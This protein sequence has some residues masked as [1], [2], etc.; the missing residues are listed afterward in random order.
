LKFFFLGGLSTPEL[1][2]SFFLAR[3]KRHRSN[4]LNGGFFLTVSRD[5]KTQREVGICD[6]MKY[7]NRPLDLRSSI[8]FLSLAVVALV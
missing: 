4:S 8:A 1:S 2:V 7:I 3:A 5:E 6:F